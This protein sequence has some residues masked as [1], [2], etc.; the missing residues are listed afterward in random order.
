MGSL[1][2]VDFSPAVCGTHAAD[3]SV[4]DKGFRAS[5]C[6]PSTR[7]TG[8]AYGKEG[9]KMGCQYTVMGAVEGVRPAGPVSAA[10]AL[11]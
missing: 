8:R 10:S 7:T 11:L 9:K 2:P 1:A 6:P 5:Y 3:S 4:V